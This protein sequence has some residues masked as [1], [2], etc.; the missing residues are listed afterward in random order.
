M[1]TSLP[2]LYEPKWCQ[3]I[4]W[5]SRFHRSGVVVPLIKQFHVTIGSINKFS[6]TLRTNM[7]RNNCRR[8]HSAIFL[9]QRK[10]EDASHSALIWL[11]LYNSININIKLGN[12]STDR[13]TQRERGEGTKEGKKKMAGFNYKNINHKR[14]GQDDM[15][16]LT[17]VSL[18]YTYILKDL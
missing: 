13:K 8:L 14:S 1:K 16:L 2:G 3:Q 18:L 10:G 5:I 15:V 4:P 7:K 12:R 9:F 6:C 11:S 17:Q